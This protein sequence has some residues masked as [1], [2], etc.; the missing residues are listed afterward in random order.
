MLPPP[1]PTVRVFTIKSLLNVL[2][3]SNACVPVVITPPKLADAGCK[4]KT[5]AVIVPPFALGVDPIAD[6][7]IAPLLITV[8]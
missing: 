6:K 3:P 5:F 2:A 7:D 4:F 8:T 1:N